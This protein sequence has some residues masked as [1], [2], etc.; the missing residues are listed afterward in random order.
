MI[1][2][3]I[4]L[5]FHDGLDNRI[6]QSEETGPSL[7]SSGLELDVQTGKKNKE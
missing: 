3:Y 7:A 1:Y 4:V 2:Y 5:P 6:V